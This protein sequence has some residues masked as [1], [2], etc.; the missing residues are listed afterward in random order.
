MSIA[1]LKDAMGGKEPPKLKQH[2]RPKVIAETEGYAWHMDGLSFVLDMPECHIRLKK[3][4]DN[5]TVCAIMNGRKYKGERPTLEQCFKV[6]DK[7]VYKEFPA[8][9]CK[10]NCSIVLEQFQ[11]DLNFD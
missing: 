5:Y 11:G 8:I 4:L 7:I 6:I 9:W 3:E 2:G 1:V 10:I